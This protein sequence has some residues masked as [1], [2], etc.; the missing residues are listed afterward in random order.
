MSIILHGKGISKNFG[1]L[2]AL[3]DVD[4]ELE[5]GEIFGLIG[6]NGS[7]KTTL[8]NVLNGVYSPKSGKIF[9]NDKDITGLSPFT[10]CQEGISRVL[11]IPRPFHSMTVLENVTIAATFGGR[12][13]AKAKSAIE[14]A[15]S[16]LHFMSIHDKKD[17]PINSITAQGRKL[18][19]MARALATEPEVLLLDEVMSGLTPVEI[20]EAMKI[21]TK[22]RDELKITVLWVEHV[23]KAIMGLAKRVMVLDH[24]RVIAMGKPGEVAKDDKVVEAYLG[25]AN[26]TV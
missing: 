26:V 24:G 2:Q 20:D 25:A 4:I 11:Q 19:E 23:M 13:R 9:F 17:L 10:I 3:Q 12:N 8:L 1:G 18:V 15:E 7:G 21:I 16:A 22:V 5:K 14:Q 6:P